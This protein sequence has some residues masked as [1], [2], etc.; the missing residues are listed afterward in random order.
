MQ[1]AIDILEDLEDVD[2]R[3]IKIIDKFEDDIDK[4]IY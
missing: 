4:E 3:I 1:A 2:P